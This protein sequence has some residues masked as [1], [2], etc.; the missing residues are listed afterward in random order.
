MSLIQISLI[1][2]VISL[3]KKE[4][5]NNNP[6]RI[7]FHKLLHQLKCW[8]LVYLLGNIFLQQYRGNWSFLTTLSNLCQNQTQNWD[9]NVCD[10]I[11][12]RV[13][14]KVPMH[15]VI[16]SYEGMSPLCLL[17]GM[18]LHLFFASHIV[19]INVGESILKYQI[20]C[21]CSKIS[22]FTKVA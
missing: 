5:L 16:F 11:I 13:R 8:F 20:L 12:V 1:R 3:G 9:L 7:L 18:M 6:D 4:Y 14:E 21:T 19:S 10:A 2:Q 15:L 17:Y 22:N